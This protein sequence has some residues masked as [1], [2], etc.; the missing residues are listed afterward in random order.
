MEKERGH[1][2]LPPAR[3]FQNIKVVQHEVTP[4]LFV[5]MSA[6]TPMG[7]SP[8]AVNGKVVILGALLYS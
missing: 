2:N 7:L 5:Y 4:V 1:H 3:S 8:M 6:P